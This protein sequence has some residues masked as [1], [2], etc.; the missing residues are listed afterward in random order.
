VEWRL[1]VAHWRGAAG[2]VGRMAYW[3]EGGLSG[4]NEAIARVDGNMCPPEFFLVEIS[5][6][7]TAYKKGGRF[8]SGFSDFSSPCPFREGGETAEPGEPVGQGNVLCISLYIL[9]LFICT[10]LVLS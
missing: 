5:S 7:R 8:G 4:V 2:D 6:Q 3:G 1:E 9:I 10:S